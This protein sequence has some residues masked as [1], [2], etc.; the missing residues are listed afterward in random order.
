MAV[1][2]AAVHCIR[3]LV[4]P[5][6]EADALSER[7]DELSITPVA[8]GGRLVHSDLVAG[9]DKVQPRTD[10]VLNETLLSFKDRFTLGYSRTIVV[11]TSQICP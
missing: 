8:V 11:D 9:F 4:I 10:A 7:L 6:S 1:K 2:E 5:A 3:R